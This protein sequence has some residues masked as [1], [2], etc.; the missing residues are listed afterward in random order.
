MRRILSQMA[1]VA[2]AFPNENAPQKEV[3]KPQT[4][5]THIMAIDNFVWN[6]ILYIFVWNLWFNGYTSH[7]V[8]QSGCRLNVW[9]IVEEWWFSIYSSYFLSNVLFS[10]FYFWDRRT[11]TTI[12]PAR[13]DLLH[14]SIIFMIPYIGVDFYVHLCVFDKIQTNATTHTR[15]IMC[16]HSINIVRVWKCPRWV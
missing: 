12:L 13:A 14:T 10:C 1:D 2:H 11:A 15:T 4:H 7:I 5:C 16:V 6:Y 9:R 3:R 8:C